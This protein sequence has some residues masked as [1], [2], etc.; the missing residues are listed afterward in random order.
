M[1]KKIA[2]AGIALLVL[3]A[4]YAFIAR[5]DTN[6]RVAEEIR[7]H[8]DGERARKTMLV[9][10]E[11]G[12]MFPVNYLEEGNLVYMG[13]DGRWWRDFRDPGA[14]ISMEIRGVSKR[15]RAMVVLDDQPYVD[16]VF[17]RLRPTVPAWL[18]DWLNGKLVV[19][20]LDD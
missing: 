2:I 10:L 19:I 11:D 13:I 20:T 8:P 1:W 6:A 15:G 12:R 3:M 7:A 4:G 16:D 9:T 18:P 17:S 14:T 5:G